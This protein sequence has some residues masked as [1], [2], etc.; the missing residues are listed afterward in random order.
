M[1]KTVLDLQ[2]SIFN[3]RIYEKIIGSRKENDEIFDGK[4]D[5][6][7]NEIKHSLNLPVEWH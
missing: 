3:N 2:H 4:F 6:I 7:F 1:L 5:I